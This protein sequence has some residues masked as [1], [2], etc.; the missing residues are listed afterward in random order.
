MAKL[1][2]SKEIWHIP[3]RGNVHQTIFMV[4]VLT[5][6]KF[7]GKSWSSGK[8]EA[9]GS[10]MGKAGLTKSGKAL[11]HQSVRTL[12]ANLP[13]YLGFVYIDES[14]KPPRVMV[15]DIGYELIRKHKTDKI[16]K[17]KNLGEYRKSEDLVET[18]GVFKKQMSKLIVTNPSIL[19]D[20]QNILVFPFRMTL[21]LLLELEYLDKEEIGYILFHT[22]KEDEFPLLM[23]KIKNFRSLAA[24]ERTAEI[25][26]YEATAEGKLTLVKAPSSVYYMYLCYSTGLCDRIYVK[27]NK[28]KES[29]LPAIKLKDK[30]LVKDL[31]KKF[32]DAEIYDFKDDWFLWKEYF[33]DPKRLYPPFDITIKTTSD[34]EILV[35]ISKSN[36][37]AGSEIISRKKNSFVVPVFRG[38]KYKIIA[39]D[40]ENGNEVYSKTVVFSR[41]NREFIIELKARKY[42]RKITKE[43]IVEQI[44]Q[45]FSKKYSGFDKEYFAKLKTLQNVLGKNY[46][47]NRRK[48]G[49]LEYLFFELLSLMREASVLDEVFWY[50]SKK[51]YGI[52]EPAPGGKEGYPDVVFEIDNNLFILELTTFHGIRAQWSSAEASSV[53]DH[54]AKFKRMSPNKKTIGIFSAPS[55]HRQLQQNL[56]LNAKKENVGMIFKPCIEFSEFLSKTNRKEL[57][58]TLIKESEEQI[59]S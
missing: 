32:K 38:E 54:I 40:M 16:S 8:Q 56:T 36:Y 49:R 17:H 25:E 39:Y 11:T 59:K 53:P 41:Q 50:G 51:K 18:S 55:I 5:W 31:L 10:E 20:C 4:H 19:Q 14:S 52:C 2:R 28:T 1:T 13:K 37:L 22:R 9:L 57:K 15:T 47:D 23:Q 46:F 33:S 30:D 26:A 45:M 29:R 44:K 12:L 7:L 27:V 35:T 43:D 58:Q 24:K 6:D 3:K 42:K 48:G 21:R 34:T